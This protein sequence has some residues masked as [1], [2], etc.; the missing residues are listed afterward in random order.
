M[1]ASPQARARTHARTR[2]HARTHT[3]TLSLTHS[4]TLSHTLSHSLSLSLSLSH[5]YTGTDTDTDTSALAHASTLRRPGCRNFGFDALFCLPSKP[6]SNLLL[7]A[8]SRR[9]PHFLLIRD[10]LCSNPQRPQVQA[11]HPH[12]PSPSLAN[13][14]CYETRQ[15]KLEMFNARFHF[16]QS[17]ASTDSFSRASRSISG[18]AEAA[19]SSA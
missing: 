12:P 10:P 18:S 14:Y 13:T 3:H 6:I 15:K 1:H 2:A 7:D 11:R 16:P 9:R 4:L 5:T 17:S 19:A 8:C